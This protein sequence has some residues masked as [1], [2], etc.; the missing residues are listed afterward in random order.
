VH[1]QSSIYCRISSDRDAVCIG[2]EAKESDC[3]RLC[4]ERGWSV[5]GRYVDNNI[6]AAD[7][8]KKRS[9][10]DRMMRDVAA[11]RIEAIIVAVDDRLHRRPVELVS[12]QCL[13]Q[14][15]TGGAARMNRQAFM[16]QGPSPSTHGWP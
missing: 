1:Y 8:T 4:E 14:V 6:T 5:V 3:R 11:G 13:R 9:E 2:V 12:R 7:P 15:G 16:P 10:Y